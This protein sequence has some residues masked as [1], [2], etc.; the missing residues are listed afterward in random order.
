MKTSMILDVTLRDG[1]LGLN[2][3]YSLEQSKT[4]LSILRDIG[5]RHV[6][7]G[8]L[9]GPANYGDEEGRSSANFH[10]D[11]GILSLLADAAP[12]VSLH[13]LA[14]GDNRN[15]NDPASYGN[16][17]SGGMIRLTVNDAKMREAKR[18]IERLAEDDLPF[19]INLKHS[20][21]LPLQ[22]FLK[23]VHAAKA[24]GAAVFYIVDTTGTMTPQQV[25]L[26][27]AE[28]RGAE[29]SLTL[30]FHG[31][32][33]LGLAVANSLAAA[34]TG[35]ELI[36]ASLGGVGAGGGNTPLEILLCLT[37]AATAHAHI[38]LQEAYSA[39]GHHVSPE[40]GRNAFWG[41]M[42]CN[43]GLRKRFKEI[44]DASGQPLEQIAWEWK[45]GTIVH[46][47][48]RSLVEKRR[49]TK[50]VPLVRKTDR[51]V[52]LAFER[53]LLFHRRASDR[54]LPVSPV[55]DEGHTAAGRYYEMPFY[56]GGTLRQR[57]HKE[58]FVSDNSLPLFGQLLSSLRQIWEGWSATAAAPEFARRAFIQRPKARLSTLECSGD[59]D[60]SRFAEWRMAD[61]I[62]T[63]DLVA[64]VGT[65]SGFVINGRRFR[66]VQSALAL[67]ELNAWL[68]EA[69]PSSMVIIHG[70]PHFGNVL[71][72]NSD[73]VVLIDSGGFDEGGD[74]AYDVG[75][76]L[77]SLGIHD[78]MLEA[79]IRPFSFRIR[80]G[81]MEVRDFRQPNDEARQAGRDRF[82]HAALRDV[83]WPH[84]QSYSQTDPF[85]KD[86]SRICEAVHLI[87]MAPTLIYRGWPA[88]ALL[89]EGSVSLDCELSKHLHLEETA[90]A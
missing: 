30:G 71:L 33:N 89:I 49:D 5:I 11:A 66:G 47:A 43:S 84:L 25:R 87:A 50:G 48:G 44:S 56:G 21:L 35:C 62:P 81:T 42:G 80:N 26:F 8:F 1:A 22:E 13:R 16:S 23:A 10:V 83:L 61:D 4:Y 38:K 19:S 75:K 86:R 55:V 32:N 15:L 85:L 51:T 78:A 46:D 20:G 53:E 3:P 6:E 59:E 74:V 79:E 76:L 60:L 77:V 39:L 9:E 69:P 72:N 2:F 63:A 65:C 88:A 73:H 82:T 34:E 17:P 28:A 70:D 37:D 54:G 14:D 7:V 41:M 40:L 24:C 58:N 45:F 36:D 52:A 67:L 18:F 64:A 57:L 27:V 68:V 12:G 90:D 31:H 29:P